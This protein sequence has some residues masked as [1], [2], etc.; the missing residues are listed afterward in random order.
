MQSFKENQIFESLLEK[1][2]VLTT[3]LGELIYNKYSSYFCFVIFYFV[4]LL[5]S[6]K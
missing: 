1:E 5:S 2:Q 3:F 6:G 4:V